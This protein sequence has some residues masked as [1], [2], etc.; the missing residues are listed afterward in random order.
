MPL[1]FAAPPWLVARLP[2]SARLPAAPRAAGLLAGVPRFGFTGLAPGLGAS[3]LPST[4]G[5]PLAF[6]AVPFAAGL[7]FRPR[8]MS[9][10]EL[11]A[12]ADAVPA[13]AVPVAA[14]PAGTG[15]GYLRS[16]QNCWPSEKRLVVTQ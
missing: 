3:A 13:R 16:T 6:A 2:S 9:V 15:G 11:I 4:F 10:S 12:G 8:I 14:L 1:A 5:A 7:D